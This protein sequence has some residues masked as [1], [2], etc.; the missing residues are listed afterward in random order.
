MVQKGKGYHIA[1]G[2]GVWHLPPP[3]RKYAMD[4]VKL[5]PRSRNGIFIGCHTDHGSTW[6]GDYIVADFE[7][8]MLYGFKTPYQQCVIRVREIYFDTNPCWEFPLRKKGTRQSLATS[9]HFGEYLS[10]I[11]I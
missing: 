6:R 11:H 5:E 3:N 10:L 2:A 4:Q 9:G 7:D 1:F 8:L